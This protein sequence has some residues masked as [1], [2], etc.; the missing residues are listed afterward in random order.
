MKTPLRPHA[1]G[2]VAVAVAA[3]AI[4]IL[5]NVAPSASATT[6]S[7][8][9]RTT[10]SCRSAALVIWLDT[11]PDA[12]A[13]SSYY[14]LEFTNLSASR[15]TIDG[16]PGVSAINLGHHQLGSA[17]TRNAAHRASPVVLNPG[18]S[19]SSVLQITEAANFPA[20]TCRR[21]LAA[22]LRVFAPNDTSASTVPFPFPVCTRSGPTFLSVEAVTHA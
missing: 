4:A 9:S 5:P 14:K 6:V 3:A 2:F 15:C 13:G 20:S 19:A 18:A 17:A 12:A 8:S 11:S 16:Y 1:H 22:G 10:S 7:A 21:G